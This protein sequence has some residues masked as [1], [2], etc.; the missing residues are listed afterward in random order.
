[1]G[2]F[3]WGCVS[4]VPPSHGASLSPASV[5]TP[6]LPWNLISGSI[7]I[8][9]LALASTDWHRLSRVATRL[10]PSS[11]AAANLVKYW[12]FPINPPVPQYLPYP[13]KNYPWP[14]GPSPSPARPLLTAS[15]NS[16]HPPRTDPLPYQDW[17][18]AFTPRLWRTQRCPK[19]SPTCPGPYQDPSLYW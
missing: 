11:A 14:S 1:M 5:K 19:P 4:C 8:T 17:R 15:F 3:Y 6:H 9:L 2:S 13:N 16:L 12:S 10:P 18:W 7:S